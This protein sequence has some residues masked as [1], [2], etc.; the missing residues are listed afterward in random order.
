MVVSGA[1]Q[2]IRGAIEES[3]LNLGLGG[4]C[5]HVRP[6]MCVSIPKY[7][8]HTLLLLFVGKC[9]SILDRKLFLNICTII[10]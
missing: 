1:C 7:W 6:P 4:T 9:L 8:V 3:E 2:A 5:L 10:D